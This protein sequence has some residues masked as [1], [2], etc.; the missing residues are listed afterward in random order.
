M[1]LEK[2]IA[3]AMDAGCLWI[4]HGKGTGRLRD[5]VHEFLKQHPLIER[6]ELAGTPEGGTGVTIAY[7]K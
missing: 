7:I 6:F 3:Q 5:G 2:A 1:A 4:I